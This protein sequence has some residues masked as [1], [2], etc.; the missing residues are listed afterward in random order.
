VTLTDQQEAIASV[1]NGSTVVIACPGSGKTMVATERILRMI[2]EGTHPGSIVAITF[3]NRAADELLARTGPGLGFCGTIHGLAHEILRM[4]AGMEGGL[5][6]DFAVWDDAKREETLGKVIAYHRLK[7]T[8]GQACGLL[9]RFT[10]GTR[11]RTGAIPSLRS[12]VPAF[13][14][15]ELYDTLKRHEN[16]EDYNGLIDRALALLRGSHSLLEML[17]QRWRHATV[18]EYQDVD[19]AQDALVELLWPAG[20]LG[21]PFARSLFI[22]GDPMQS[23]Y[24]FR[25]GDPSIALRR[26]D[27]ADTVARLDFNFRAGASL[28]TALGRLASSYVLPGTEA[29]GYLLAMRYEDE[30]HEA[31]GVSVTVAPWLGL[32]NFAVLCRTNAQIEKMAARLESFGLPLFLP[33][34]GHAPNPAEA[35]TVSTIHAAKGLEWDTVILPG[36]SEGLFP[37]QQAIEAFAKGD[38]EPMQDERRLAYVAISRAKRQVVILSPRRVSRGPWEPRGVPAAPSR[39]IGEMGLELVGEGS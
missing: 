22:V 8:V 4:G 28:C 5:R 6:A 2:R 24:A 16:A 19:P 36:W 32:Q 11:W 10:R 15:C 26:A 18:D 37:S 33:G 13:E 25:G 29:E 35:M 7:T 38:K 14:A 3:T 30:A 17:R 9:D 23:I 20:A 31:T 1:R 12:F 21:A 27:A 39:F 34:S